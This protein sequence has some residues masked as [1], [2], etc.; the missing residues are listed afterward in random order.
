LRAM[1]MQGYLAKYPC[2]GRISSSGGGVRNAWTVVTES[3]V[4]SKTSTTSGLIPL[5]LER[6]F[7]SVSLAAASRHRA[8]PLQ[9]CGCEKRLEGMGFR[10]LYL[11]P[12]VL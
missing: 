7:A 4:G 6:L 1:Q 2:I 3:T 10:G 12:M 5:P 8:T 9:R 11:K